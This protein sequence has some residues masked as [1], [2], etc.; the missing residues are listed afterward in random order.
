ML[1]L[2]SATV[3]CAYVPPL[4]PLARRPGLT[5]TTLAFRLEP[6][7]QHSRGQHNFSLTHTAAL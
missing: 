6:A 4:L 2:P 5:T 1:P 3:I 7:P